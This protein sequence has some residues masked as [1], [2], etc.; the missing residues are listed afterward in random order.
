MG[1]FDFLE[2]VRDAVCDKVEDAVDFVC[3]NPI[4]SIGIAVATVATG[5]L[6]GTVIGGAGVA[7][8]LAAT[9]TAALTGAGA[10][11]AGVATKAGLS[12]TAKAI[13][14]KSAIEY[15]KNKKDGSHNHTTNTG[16]DR[17]PAQKEGDKKRR[18]ND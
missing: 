4:K 8:G 9:G 1:L 16:S 2:D 15:G 11:A 3:D 6:A 10:T 5:G 12:E 17:T 7:A 13:A 14:I 18:K